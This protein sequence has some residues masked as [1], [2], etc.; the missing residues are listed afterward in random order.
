ME[1]KKGF[2]LLELLI[3]IAILAILASAVIVVINPAEILK[4]SRDTRRVS[5]LDSLRLALALYVTDVSSPDLD[6]SGGSCSTDEWISIADAAASCRSSASTCNK[7][8]SMAVNGSG[9]V[10]VDLTSISTGSPI[11][12]LPIDPT[13]NATYFYSYRCD[14]SNTTFEL[15]AALES[16]YYTSTID[17][18][19][20]DGGNSDTLYEVGTDPG[21][22]L[23]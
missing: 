16:N 23:I 10:P 21:L 12:S 1:N 18:D 8:D 15:D 17:S 9:W 2:T 11:A 4:K 7:S 14:S 5:D 3:V 20:K 6:G 19:G 13:N 22:D